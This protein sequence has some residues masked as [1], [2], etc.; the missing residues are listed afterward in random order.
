MRIIP[1]A[2]STVEKDKGKLICVGETAKNF[3]KIGTIDCTQYNDEKEA[4]PAKNNERRR[5][6]NHIRCELA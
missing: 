1:I 2:S 3:A 6:W 5:T 4:N